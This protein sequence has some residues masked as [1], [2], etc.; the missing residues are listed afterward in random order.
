MRWLDYFV[1]KEKNLLYSR[2]TYNSSG[3]RVVEIPIAI[4]FC[5]S[6]TSENLLEIGN[7]LAY[8]ED[9]FPSDIPRRIIDKYEKSDQVENIDLMELE[10]KVQYDAIISISTIE[11]I[12]Q[13]STCYGD[14]TI[15][16][17]RDRE[18][19]LKA[20]AKIYRLLSPGGRALITVPYGK[21]IDGIWLIQFSEE[22]S[23]FLLDSLPPTDISVRYL[24]R[25]GYELA[26]TNPRQTWVEVSPKYLLTTDFHWPFPYANGIAVIE[27][28]KS[29][30]NSDSLIFP[31]SP[32]DLFYHKSV[33]D[34]FKLEDR[35]QMRIEL[36]SL[37]SH[38][39]VINLVVVPEL[40]NSESVEKT[41]STIQILASHPDRDSI[42]LLVYYDTEKYSETDV[43][44][45]LLVLSNL[46]VD[47]GSMKVIPFGGLHQIQME[48]IKSL[49][50]Y[51][52]SLADGDCLDFYIPQIALDEV[53]NQ[54]LA[55]LPNGSLGF[56]NLV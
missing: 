42:S 21:L 56:L 30:N 2:H 29:S 9:L 40:Y 37:F 33:A 24:K 31:E 14:D 7:V 22:Y 6:M 35:R 52:I 34:L 15:V 23:Q 3:E 26:P 36:F 45:F 39:N 51:Q 43:N 12:G 38:F 54:R 20:I 11:H 13:D 16:I 19:P 55:E 48:A 1:F 44:S 28:I 27:L 8:Y 17:N 25:I 32:R 50:S 18:A 41:I 10:E 47:F 4:D 53:V 49:I 46:E 5:L